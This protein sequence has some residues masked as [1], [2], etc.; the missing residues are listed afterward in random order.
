MNMS[1]VIT[2][3]NTVLSLVIV[4]IVF[5]LNRE[6]KNVSIFLVFEVCVAR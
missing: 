2:K 5:F 3:D 1:M 4:K 6:K